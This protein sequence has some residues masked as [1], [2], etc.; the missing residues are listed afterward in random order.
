M[1]FAIQILENYLYSTKRRNRS[2]KLKSR[3]ELYEEIM[4]LKRRLIQIVDEKGLNHLLAIQTSQKLDRLINE[5]MK[6]AQKK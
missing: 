1:S 3:K 4:F 2:L 5:Y 6:L